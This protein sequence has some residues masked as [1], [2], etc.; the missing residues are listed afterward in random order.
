MR[1]FTLPLSL[2]GYFQRIKIATIYSPKKKICRYLQ[3]IEDITTIT[4]QTYKF[5]G[6]IYKNYISSILKAKKIIL[7]FSYHPKFSIQIY[8]KLVLNIYKSKLNWTILDTNE[9]PMALHF[10][11]SM[12]RACLDY[13]LT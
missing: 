1:P 7:L 10:E 12:W 3:H 11:I 5:Y 4:K 2:Q 6:Q 9:K 8:K 13:F